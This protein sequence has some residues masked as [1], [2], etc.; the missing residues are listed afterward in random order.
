[1]GD[2]G[3]RAVLV[4]FIVMK[5]NCQVEVRSDVE[6]VR[7]IYAGYS[8]L[9][10]GGFLDLKQIIPDDVLEDRS[11]PDRWTDYRF[12]N[13]KVVINGTVRVLYDLHDRGWIDEEILAGV[14]F[15]FKRSF[16][17]EYVSGLSEGK[18]VSPLGLN[19]PVST[20]HVDLFKLQRARLYSGKDKLKMIAKALRLDRLGIRPGETDIL[21]N[22]EEGPNPVGEPRILYMARLWDPEHLESKTQSDTVREMNDMRAECVRLLRKEFGTRFFG[23]LARDDYSLRNYADCVLADTSLSNKRNYLKTLRG[24]PICVATTGL[25]GSNGWKLGEYTAFSKAIITEPLRFVV[26]GD[27]QPESNYLEFRTPVD[28]AAAAARLLENANL[29]HEMMRNNQRYYEAYVRP[30]A[31]VRNTLDIALSL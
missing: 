6:H 15:Y 23:G 28:L 18:K 10:R 14:D 31:L 2:A 27:F 4:E 12:F 5:L 9:H 11:D 17:R 29:R 16:D 20:S 30:E 13:V 25:S 3:G 26:T 24:F 22:L 19:Y 8:L 21:D 7:Q 1:V